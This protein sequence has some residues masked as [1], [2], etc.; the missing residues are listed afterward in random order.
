VT[1]A[2]KRIETILD[3][4]R[5]SR[6]AEEE[7]EEEEEEHTYDDKYA[8]TEFLTNTAIAAQVNALEQLGL[9]PEL[10]QT[11]SGWVHDDK[12][13]VTLR[14]LSHCATHGRSLCFAPA[15]R[16]WELSSR[17]RA[18]ALMRRRNIYPR[19]THRVN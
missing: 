3:T 15:R 10:L 18:V 6:L 8:S 19:F 16:T 9:T 4:T 11:V 2:L 7:E 14:F 13:T 5:N 17:N 12:E 1:K